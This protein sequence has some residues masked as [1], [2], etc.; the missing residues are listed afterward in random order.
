MWESDPVG[1][2]TGGHAGGGSSIGAAPAPAESNR[3]SSSSSSLSLSESI[4]S[5]AG[6][7]ALRLRLSDPPLPPPPLSPLLPPLA[8]DD[9]RLDCLAAMMLAR[10]VSSDTVGWGA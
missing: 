5:P 6:N 3:N 10:L 9:F 1:S 4:P 8:V 2:N 7:A